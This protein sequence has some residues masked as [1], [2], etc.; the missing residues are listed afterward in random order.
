[1]QTVLDVFLYIVDVC[2]LFSALGMDVW[3]MEIA[4][5]SP[6]AALAGGGLIGA[7]AVV[8]MLVNGRIM[9]IAGIVGG[10]LDQPR[11]TDSGWRLAFLAGLA[12]P[13]LVAG[14]WGALPASPAA[15]IASVLIA[16]FLVGLGSRMGN[17]CTSGHGICGLAR[18]S[19]RSLAAVAT[20]MVVAAATAVVV[21][22]VWW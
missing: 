10:V 8:L 11:S 15:G 22:H 12:V 19:K 4:D 2:P 14:F 7:A 16:G 6:L 3:T 9:G 21:N 13:G 5:F 20:F 1:M 17:G 18:L